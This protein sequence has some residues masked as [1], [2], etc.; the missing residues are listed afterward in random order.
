MRRVI[1]SIVV[2][3]WSATL[4]VAGTGFKVLGTKGDVKSGGKAIRIGQKI[5]PTATVVIGRTGSCTLV[6][7]NGRTVP[8][9]KP[10]TYKITE[11][12]KAA[13]AKTGSVSSKYAEYVYGELTE[14]QKPTALAD[15]HR[16][17][18]RTTGAV[19]R[20]TGDNVSVVDSIAL[21]SGGLHGMEGVA[22]SAYADIFARDEITPIMPRNARIIDESVEFHWFRSAKCQAYRLHIEDPDKKTVFDQIVLDT[23]FKASL[24]QLQL[25]PGILYYWHVERSDDDGLRSEEQSMFVLEETDRMAA[26][27]TIDD[28]R[29]ELGDDPS[30]QIILAAAYEDLGCTADAFLSYRRALADAPGDDGYE[31][32]FLGFLKRNGLDL[33]ER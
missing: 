5:A 7:E 28:I 10:G 17:N 16:G 9:K 8:L 1:L 33:T 15:G 32:L 25:K 2:A 3:L 13:T 30:A 4:L 21:R 19:E 27:R 14:V 20:A 12:E 6:H 22:S 26:Q 23:T 24:T 31:R 18:M 11:L 29:A